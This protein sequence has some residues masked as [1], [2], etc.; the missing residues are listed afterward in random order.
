MSGDIGRCAGC[1][2]VGR[3]VDTTAGEII[4][5]DGLVYSYAHHEEEL[6]L[7]GRE[8]GSEPDSLFCEACARVPVSGEGV[9]DRNG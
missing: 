6:L 3:H 5:P 1:G 2:C 4:D 8:D 9:A 7:V